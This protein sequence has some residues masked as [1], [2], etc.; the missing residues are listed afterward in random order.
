MTSSLLALSMIF[1]ESAQAAKEGKLKKK[2]PA[3]AGLFNPAQ[4][5]QELALA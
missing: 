2:G 3:K 4:R 5:S 1:T